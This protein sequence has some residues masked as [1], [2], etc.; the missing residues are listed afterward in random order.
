MLL[1]VCLMHAQSSSYADH[2]QNEGAPLPRSLFSEVSVMLFG[3]QGPTISPSSSVNK[4]SISPAAQQLDLSLGQSGERGKKTRKSLH[5]PQTAGPISLDLLARKM[6]V[7]S[8]FQLP[9]PSLERQETNKKPKSRK[10]PQTASPSSDFSSSSSAYLYS[11]C[12]CIL[13]R[14]LSSNQQKR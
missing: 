1:W 11:S 8:E 14:A 13:S 6:R 9:V 10:H 4:G 12:S 3:S 5:V 2:I 7:L